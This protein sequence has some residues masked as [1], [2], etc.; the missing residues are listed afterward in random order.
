M[1]DEIREYQDPLVIRTDNNGTSTLTLNRPKSYN[2]LS[3]SLMLELQTHLDNIRID[4]S[5]MVVV[6]KGAGPGFSA[7]HD[8]KEMRNNKNEVFFRNLFEQCS[9]LMQS[10]I[11]L[12]QPVIAQI[13]GTAA[14]AGCQLVATCDLAV[15]SITAKFATPGVNIGLF[16]STPMVAVSRKL[17][18][19]KMM[20]MLLMGD[21]VD[22]ETALEFGL[23]NRVV[24]YEQLEKT[25]SNYANKIKEKSPLVLKIGK[26]AFYNQIDMPLAD[27]YKYTAE[28]MT[29][30]ML[31][32]DAN[33]GID[34]FIEKRVPNWTG[35]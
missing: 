29:Q 5:I 27:A 8:L 14:A 22:A 21:L 33:E 23:I 32:Q 30:N 7:G 1:S 31:V 10:I 34:A 15:A 35:K 20:E 2:A 28:V 9:T 13:H 17:P 24:A 3:Q 25:V 19:K 6:I 4:Q 18:R 12:P 16:C 26:E 11:K